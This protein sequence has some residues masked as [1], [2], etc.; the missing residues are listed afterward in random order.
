MNKHALDDPQQK[1]KPLLS[2]P[3]EELATNINKKRSIVSLV[4]FFLFLLLL[5]GAGTVLFMVPGTSTHSGKPSS[6]SNNAN[7]APSQEEISYPQLAHDKAAQA[8]LKFFSLKVKAEGENITAWAEERYRITLAVADRADHLLE[9]KKYTEAEIQYTEAF[10]ELSSL[11][12][13]KFEMFQT[14][15]DQGFKAIKEEK[16]LKAIKYFEK[17]LAIKPEN[18]EAEKGLRRGA[19][20]D[21]VIL[22]F[23]KAM[24][25]ESEGK[26]FVAEAKLI[27]L[28]E[29]DNAYLPGKNSLERIQSRIKEQTFQI[30][31]GN[32]Y[33][34][35]G[36]N[37]LVQ[38]RKS[39]QLLKQLEIK[40]PK[41][42]QAEKLLLDKELS[43]HLNIL[44]QKAQ[45]LVDV[46]KW[47]K[48]LH[49]YQQALAIAPEALFAQTGRTIAQKRSDLDKALN[50]IITRRSRLQND[51][52]RKAAEK[53]LQYAWVISPKGPRLEAQVIKLEQLII[54]ATTPV[55]VILESDDLTKLVMYHVGNLG[56]FY[57][58]RL[59]LKPG[60][61]TVVGSRQ[62]F[63][64]VRKVIHIDQENEVH[65]F[66]IQCK[67][68]I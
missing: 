21:A 61:Y 68:P 23:Q 17:A 1:E 26:L 45:E 10:T 8:M 57:E 55:V 20:L 14:F 28:L 66:F 25:F 63:R 60:K 11:L 36:N 51:N 18:K 62:G 7:R 40:A 43:L 50:D 48:A 31:M 56:H 46:E 34:A 42:I 47:Q 19:T 2:P 58:K 67:E 29:L 4:L 64:D 49:V 38:A 52:Q 3:T 16:S 30:E 27:Q 33:R 53:L 13:E 37:Q 59:L 9:E 6:I 12:D 39:I 22:L 44:R 24:A 15:L 65:R 54:Q 32:F 5:V 35:L 41:V